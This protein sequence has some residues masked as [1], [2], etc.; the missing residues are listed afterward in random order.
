MAVSE[1]KKRANAKYD[2]KAYEDVRVR[3]KRGTKVKIESAAKAADSSINAYI[4]D[5]VKRRILEET[6]EK[7]DL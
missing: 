4:K 5:A 3:V 1:A 2:K 7:I 6:G